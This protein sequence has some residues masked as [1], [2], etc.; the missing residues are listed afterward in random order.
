MPSLSPAP[1]PTTTAPDS[2][3]D[4]ATAGVGPL[5]GQYAIPPR[6]KPG[7]KPATDEPANKRKAQ[8][9]QSQR[10]F[11]LR[12]QQKTEELEARIA[13]DEKRHCEQLREKE[14]E[15]QKLNESNARLQEILKGA[16]AQS[17]SLQAQVSSVSQERDYFSRERDYWKNKFEQLESQSQ[18]SAFDQHRQYEQDFTTRHTSFSL[19]GIS[20]SHRESPTR[21]TVA[22]ILQTLHGGQTMSGLPMSGQMM[23]GRTVTGQAVDGGC[24]NCEAGGKCACVDELTQIPGP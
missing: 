2:S 23:N 18:L 15:I 16:Q 6:P 19:D 11:R 7:R 24:G 3:T 10:N 1:I 8:N 9:R 21:E 4:P 14:I 5:T 17:A 20:G 13:A 12:K 22:H